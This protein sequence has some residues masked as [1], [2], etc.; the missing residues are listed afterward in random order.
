MVTCPLLTLKSIYEGHYNSFY[1]ILPIT[2]QL[3]QREREAC[4]ER[5]GP[6]GDQ[7][8]LKPTHARPTRTQLPAG[9]RELRLHRRELT[10]ELKVRKGA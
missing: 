2:G 8:G 4:D 3:V 9:F 10:G 7:G 1:F 6:H 5:Q